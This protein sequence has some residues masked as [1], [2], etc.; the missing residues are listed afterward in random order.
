MGALVSWNEDGI[1]SP[2]LVH[3]CVGDL[4]KDIGDATNP[5]A[6]PIVDLAQ[7]CQIL[8]ELDPATPATGEDKGP[9]GIEDLE[10]LTDCILVR[11]S[12]RIRIPRRTDGIPSTQGG[13]QSLGQRC[14]QGVG[15]PQRDLLRSAPRATVV[16]TKRCARTIAP[17]DLRAPPLHFIFHRWPSLSARAGGS[18]DSPSL[19][20]QSLRLHPHHGTTLEDR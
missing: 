9:N 13:P 6:E 5:A 12:G 14:A 10:R 4:P 20:F 17:D 3:I 8:I 7:P 2:A 18:R 16:V 11:L 1:Q 15:V 19:D